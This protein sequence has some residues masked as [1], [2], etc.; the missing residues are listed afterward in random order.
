MKLGEFH[1]TAADGR[2]LRSV[3]IMSG[4]RTAVVP[5]FH[6]EDGIE[7]VHYEVIANQNTRLRIASIQADYIEENK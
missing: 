6:F 5:E 7:E 4:Q 2:V 3:D 1:I